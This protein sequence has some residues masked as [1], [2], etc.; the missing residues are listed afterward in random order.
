MGQN[1]VMVVGSTHLVKCD[2]WCFVTVVLNFLVSC[3]DY[4]SENYTY[5]NRDGDG[6]S[7]KLGAPVSYNLEGIKGRL[8]LR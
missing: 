4:G 8:K 3:K 5:G 2:Q 6:T 1:K 7:E